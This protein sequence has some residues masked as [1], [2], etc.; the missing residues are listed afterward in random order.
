[1]DEAREVGGNRIHYVQSS[2]PLALVGSDNRDWFDTEQSAQ[3]A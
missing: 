1:M 3:L 2:M